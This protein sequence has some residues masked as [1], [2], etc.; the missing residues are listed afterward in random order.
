[1]IGGG[2]TAA[3][4]V[5]ELFGGGGQDVEDV[6]SDTRQ[7]QYN[8][9]QLQQLK[10]LVETTDKEVLENIFGRETSQQLQEQVQRSFGTQATDT[11][12]SQEESTTAQTDQNTLTELLQNMQ[13]SVTEQQSQA[14]NQQQN[15]QTSTEEQSVLNQL[16]NVLTQTDQT[17][18]EST[19]QTSSTTGTQTEEQQQTVQRG[20]AGTQQA[21]SQLQQQLSGG[22]DVSGAMDAAIARVLESGAPAI[23]NIT[24]RSGTFNNSM[25]AI[26][27]GK[28]MEE[29]ARSAAGIQL[30]QDA[31]TNEQLLQAIQAGQAGTETSTGT[32]TTQTAQQQQMQQ[33]LDAV[34][35]GRESTATDTQQQQQ[36][37]TVQDM[38]SQLLGQTDTT[39]SQQTDQT[40]SSTEQ[41]QMSQLQDMFTQMFGSE[42]ANTRTTQNTSTATETTT[43]ATS[44]QQR[45][46]SESIESAQTEST[47]QTQRG[48]SDAWKDI[49]GE[50]DPYG[51]G[52]LDTLFAGGNASGISVLGELLN[53]ANGVDGEIPMPGGNSGRPNGGSGEYLGPGPGAN[54]SPNP[55][56]GGPQMGARNE[57][58]GTSGGG[59]PAGE[60]NIINAGRINPSVPS[61]TMGSQSPNG[62]QYFTT[63][64]GGRGVKP[65]TSSTSPMPGNITGGQAT[66]S[67]LRDSVYDQNGVR[68]NDNGLPTDDPLSALLAGDGLI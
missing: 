9:Q 44:E 7:T 39:S 20:D 59:T 62:Q 33:L 29:A 25:Q 12:T 2:V 55:G 54:P 36:T 46:A 11:R 51:S 60:F 6:M 40:T 31:R 41:T 22:T 8:E 68:I 53:A 65:P 10:E 21:L 18:Q 43:E 49:A 35:Q 1:M 64:V 45:Q 28:L 56:M 19:E 3:L 66:A 50:T 38:L 47:D 32:G 67:A 24:G 15:Q 42:R 30:D 5:K 16:Q 13:Q 23:A 63:P 14:Q 52:I 61:N 58:P 17:Q 57:V 4:G 26:A 48:Y 37:S 34:T 27:Q